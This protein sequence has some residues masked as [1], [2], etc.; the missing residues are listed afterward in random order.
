MIDDDECNTGEHNCDDN[1]DCI[2]TVG[3][4]DCMCRQSFFGDGIACL[5]EAKDDIIIALFLI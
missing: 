2:N 4:F 5:C 3:S 1:A